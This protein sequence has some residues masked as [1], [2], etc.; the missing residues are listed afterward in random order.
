MKKFALVM[1]VVF[2][3]LSGCA[4]IRDAAV[5]AT[6]VQYVDMTV[7]REAPAVR[8][9][10]MTACTCSATFEWT[11]TAEG[12]TTE[13]CAASA[14][15]YRVYAQRWPWHIA[16]IQYNGSMTDTDPGPVPEIVLSCDLPE[17]PPASGGAS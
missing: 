4:T 6:E 13:E 8:R 16:M 11:A 7:R 2:A 3:A 17:L 1:L 15:W 5:Y 12:V 9:F 14:D 10:L